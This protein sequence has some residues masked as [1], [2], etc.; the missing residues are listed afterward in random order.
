MII[1]IIKVLKKEVLDM[2]GSFK[3]NDVNKITKEL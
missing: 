3:Y 2:D 1:N